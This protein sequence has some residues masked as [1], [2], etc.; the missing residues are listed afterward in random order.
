MCG[1]ADYQE[2]SDQWEDHCE[3][4]ERMEIADA[5][6][7]IAATAPSVLPGLDDIYE[8]IDN[9]EHFEDLHGHLAFVI[10]YLEELQDGE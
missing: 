1:L 4:A 9:I 2:V 7:T 5:Y 8:A 6:D 10:D 3:R